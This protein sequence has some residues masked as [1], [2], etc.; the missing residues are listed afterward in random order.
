M[1]TPQMKLIV[2]ATLTALAV[3]YGP[4]AQAQTIYDGDDGALM[5]RN[6]SRTPA[7]PT[8]FDNVQMAKL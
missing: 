2:S 7:K 8:E 5:L 4:A 1:K 6:V 3:A